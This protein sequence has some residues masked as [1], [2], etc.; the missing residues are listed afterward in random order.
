MLQ[1]RRLRVRFLMRSSFFNWPNPSSCNMALGS[2]QPLTEMSTRNLPKGKGQPVHKA[3]NLITICEPTVQK[4]CA[5]RRLTTLQASMASYRNSFTFICL[6]LLIEFR[7]RSD[8][9]TSTTANPNQKKPVTSH[10][11]NM[12]L[13][14]TCNINTQNLVHTFAAGAGRRH[15][16]FVNTSINYL[17]G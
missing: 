14:I 12:A 9:V 15:R 6:P 10:N 8:S 4:M 7:W 1:A 3:D 17:W 11:L 5:P 16:P 2:T 13:P